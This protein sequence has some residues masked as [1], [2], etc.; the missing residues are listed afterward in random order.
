MTSHAESYRF[1]P[2]NFTIVAFWSGCRR[3]YNKMVQNSLFELIYTCKHVKS[4]K[5]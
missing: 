5:Q 3:I 4:Y 2:E 1:L